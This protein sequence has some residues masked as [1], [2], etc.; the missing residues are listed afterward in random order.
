MTGTS[1][2]ADPMRVSANTSFAM[3]RNVIASGESAAVGTVTS[4][5]PLSEADVPP[6]SREETPESRKS[7]RTLTSPQISPFTSSTIEYSP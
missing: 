4:V 2:I 5:I 7:K 3:M 1:T 6:R